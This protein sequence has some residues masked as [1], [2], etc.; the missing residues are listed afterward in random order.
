MGRPTLLACCGLI[1][2]GA[3]AGA[4]QVVVIPGSIRSIPSPDAAGGRIF[5]HPH[6]LPNGSQA[7]PVF[8]QDGK[9]QSTTGRHSVAKYGYQLVAGRRKGFPARQL[10]QRRCGLL[11]ADARGARDQALKTFQADSAHARSSDGGGATRS[12]LCSLRSLALIRSDRRRSQRP[13]G[14]EPRAWLPPSLQLQRAHAPNGL[15]A[16]A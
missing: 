10:G 14:Y 5:Y 8:Y 13:Y 2:A 1:I 6:V 11:R 9:G 16:L 7:S 12:L 3:T 4:P 15:A